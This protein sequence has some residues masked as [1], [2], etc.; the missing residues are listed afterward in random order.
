[1]AD[2]MGAKPNY[3]RCAADFHNTNNGLAAFP[4]A[5]RFELRQAFVRISPPRR[6]VRI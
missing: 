6:D 3:T 5:V 1:M 4:L 2:P